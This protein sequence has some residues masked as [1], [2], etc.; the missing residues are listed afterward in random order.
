[1]R[2]RQ[3]ATLP[4]GGRATADPFTAGRPCA[5]LRA[6]RDVV[7]GRALRFG[8]AGIKRCSQAVHVRSEVLSRA[9]DGPCSRAGV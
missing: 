7:F 8:R 9:F 6:G 3:R 2:R 5:P 1:M 4:S